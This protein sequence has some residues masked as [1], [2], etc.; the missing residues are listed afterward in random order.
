ME[1]QN[2]EEYRKQRLSALVRLYQSDLLRLC[3]VCLQ[4]A[5]QAEDAVQ[6]TFIK[7]YRGLTHFRGESSEKTWLIRI[8]INTCRDM[9]RSAWFRHMNRRV[10]PEMLPDAAQAFTPGDEELVLAIM[11]LPDKLREVIVL[12]YDQQM[13]VKEI[14]ALYGISS[15]AVSNRLARARNML[16]NALEGRQE[17]E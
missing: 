10:T 1:Q 4:D 16:R 7:A 13:S 6:E 8:A 14:A 11:N 9:R 3:C 15:P 5:S 2:P 17:D 12:H